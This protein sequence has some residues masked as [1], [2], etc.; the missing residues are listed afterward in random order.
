VRSIC[1]RKRSLLAR[2]LLAGAVGRVD[3]PFQLGQ[4]VG[5]WRVGVQREGDLPGPAKVEV[6]GA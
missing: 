4:L 3:F 2:A 1:R 5:H 6:P